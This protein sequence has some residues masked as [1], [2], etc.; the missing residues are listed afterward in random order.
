MSLCELLNQAIKQGWAAEWLVAVAGEK[1]GYIMGERYDMDYIYYINGSPWHG[2]AHYYEYPCVFAWVLLHD[3]IG[4]QPSLNTDVLISPR[5]IDKG[6]VDLK[7]AVSSRHLYW[8][9]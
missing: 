4:V 8:K 5:L 2:A 7:Q 9:I 3:Y 6:T 1:E